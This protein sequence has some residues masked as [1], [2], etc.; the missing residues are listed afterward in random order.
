MIMIADYFVNLSMF[1]SYFDHY[2]ELIQI[3]NRDEQKLFLSVD[4]TPIHKNRHASSHL[5][6][7]YL[8][9]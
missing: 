8:V 1:N 2:P 7:K 4:D 3:F 9:N 6:W 5:F